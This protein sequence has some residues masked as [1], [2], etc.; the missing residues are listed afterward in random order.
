M[1]LDLAWKI[2]MKAR[3]MADIVTIDENSVS[4]DMNIIGNHCNLS[5]L[6]CRDNA[7]YS[8]SIKDLTT[9]LLLFEL[10]SD[11]IISQKNADTRSGS[12]F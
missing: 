1:C 7:L 5:D 3:L 11:D 6:S 2:G 12:L 10:S 8:A 4:V 9:G